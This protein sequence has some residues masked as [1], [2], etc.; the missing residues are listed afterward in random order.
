M[1]TLLAVAAFA[2]AAAMPGWQDAHAQALSSI[3]SVVQRHVQGLALEHRGDDK[4]AFIAFL[5]AAERG[6]PPAQRR[7]GEI[8]DTGNSAVERTYEESIR[9]IEKARAG[10]EQFP[11]H[12]SPMPTAAK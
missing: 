2:F 4:G 9:W 12:R 3:E 5:D 10:G 6:Y 7:V 1:K 11:P 8:Y